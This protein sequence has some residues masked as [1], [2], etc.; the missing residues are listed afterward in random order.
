MEQKEL[1]DR[2]RQNPAAAQKVMQSPDG[3]ALMRMLT[4]DGGGSLNR[5]MMQAA[6]GNTADLAAMIRQVM[7]SPEGAALIQNIGNSLQK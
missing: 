4:T 6:G 3:Q 7:Q 1:M 2:L 5:A